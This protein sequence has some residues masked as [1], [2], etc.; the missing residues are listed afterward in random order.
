ME[1][2]IYN[3]TKK[4]EQDIYHDI[5]YIAQK[6]CSFFVLVI[7]KDIGCGEKICELQNTLKPFLIRSYES[8]EW[9]GTI[10]LDDCACV[11]EYKLCDDT[12][13]ILRNNAK[14]LFEWQQ[15]EFPEDLCFMRKAGKPWLISISHENDA[16]VQMTK[17]EYQYIAE[18]AP[19]LSANLWRQRDEP[20][21]A[22]DE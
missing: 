7:R 22:N 1:Y 19:N 21:A 8:K 20:G 18:H 14:S 9:P 3:F 6:L 15:P 2:N 11:Y 16:Y 12:A 17:K 13:I 5:L 4:P 10:L